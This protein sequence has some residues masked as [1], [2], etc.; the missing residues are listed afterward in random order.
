MSLRSQD[1]LLGFFVSVQGPTF[2]RDYGPFR[3]GPTRRG[4][5]GQRQAAGVINAKSA[6]LGRRREHNMNLL[7]CGCGVGLPEFVM[8]VILQNLPW[9]FAGG[10]FVAAVA[11][12]FTGMHRKSK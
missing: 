10:L 1:S 4:E 3:N 9:L 7:A 12:C 2:A 11:A 5:L 8:A 6:R